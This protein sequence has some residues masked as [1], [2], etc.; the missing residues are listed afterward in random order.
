M[1]VHV[2][3]GQTASPAAAVALARDLCTAHDA[4]HARI[5]TFAASGQPAPP[6]P[7]V[8]IQLKDFTGGPCPAPEPA[9]RSMK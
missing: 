3:S 6:A 9:A 5:I 7:A 2:Y 1:K 8:R 4:A